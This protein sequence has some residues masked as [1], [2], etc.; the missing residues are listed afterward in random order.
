M[1]R[2]IVVL[3]YDPVWIES[4][5]REAA[6]LAGLLGEELVAVHH[7]GSTSVPGLA[8]KPIVDM[9]VEV[10]A[11]AAID[12]LTPALVERGYLARGEFGI[13]GRRYLIKGTIEERSHHI[14][15]YEAGN[16]EIA[17]HLA[18]RDYLR[19][20]AEDAER[21]A[22][23]KRA[24]AAVYPHD[25]ESYAAGKEALAGEIERKALRWRASGEATEKG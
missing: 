20:H 14:H 18:F 1:A 15:I 16:P 19:T 10:R 11:I 2:R 23:L 13:P 22:R 5:R 8:A 7:I 3:T 6:V 21:Y 24:L 25:A 4:F 17:R 12:D 9:L